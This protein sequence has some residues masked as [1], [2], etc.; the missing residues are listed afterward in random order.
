MR[1]PCLVGWNAAAALGLHIGNA[2]AVKAGFPSPKLIISFRHCVAVTRTSPSIIVDNPAGDA[3]TV[4]QDNTN[5][6]EQA[7]S[8][9]RARHASTPQ[10]CESDGTTHRPATRDTLSSDVSARGLQTLPRPS[11]L[12]MAIPSQDGAVSVL[13]HEPP[14]SRK[15]APSCLP[16]RRATGRA[17]QS[18][19][20]RSARGARRSRGKWES[21]FAN[22]YGTNTQ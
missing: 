5:P 10:Q 9:S 16:P 3:T 11:L 14:R 4:M 15:T 2:H 13:N 6:A 21:T 18:S 20:Q 19:G 1:G 7:Y 22:C 17:S 12:S 8:T